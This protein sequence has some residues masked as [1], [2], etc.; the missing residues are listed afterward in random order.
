MAGDY[1]SSLNKFQ[2]LL[3]NDISNNLADNCQFWIG[4]IYFL[5]N[6]YLSAINEFNKVLTYKNSNKSSNSIY[7]IGLCFT[8]LNN[9]KEAI[10]SF[11]TI[12]NNYPKSKYFNKSNEFLLNLK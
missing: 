9:N 5:Q 2:F 12:I 4:Q 11:E 6:D 1:N 10:S 3:D 7:K 8:K